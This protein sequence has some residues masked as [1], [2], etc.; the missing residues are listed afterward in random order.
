MYWSSLSKT[1]VTIQ[2]KL[3][4]RAKRGILKLTGVHTPKRFL[5]MVEMTAKS[6]VLRKNAE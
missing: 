6:T 5:P 3:S 1:Q 2:R 4:F